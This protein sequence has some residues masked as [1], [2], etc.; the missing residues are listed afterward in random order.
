MADSH[1]RLVVRPLPTEMFRYAREDTH[2]LLYIYD[3]LRNEL[4]VVHLNLVRY[5]A[6]KFANRGESLDDLIQVATP[7]GTEVGIVERLTLGY[8]MLRTMDDRLVIVPNSLMASQVSLNLNRR[9]LYA[10]A[11]VQI[12]VLKNSHVGEVRSTLT[13]LAQNNGRVHRIIGVH[14]QS[15]DEGFIVSIFYA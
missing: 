2:Y 13:E 4:V 10:M 12:C 15:L 6:V 3:R 5:L 8:T 11:I 7:T 1:A 14:S 9:S